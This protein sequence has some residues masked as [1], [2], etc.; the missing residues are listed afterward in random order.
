MQPHHDGHICYLQE[1]VVHLQPNEHITHLQLMSHTVYTADYRLHMY[2]YDLTSRA[3]L[4][5]WCLVTRLFSFSALGLKVKV[6]P[7]RTADSQSTY[8]CASLGTPAGHH[9]ACTPV[10]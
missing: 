1:S 7:L 3:N 9:M 6:T 2:S 8:T 5:K 4:F 10:S